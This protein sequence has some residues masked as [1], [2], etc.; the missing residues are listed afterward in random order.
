MKKHFYKFLII[1]SIISFG[2]NIYQFTKQT[3]SKEK[4]YLLISPYKNNNTID[5]NQETNT[6]IH[7]VNLKPKLEKILKENDINQKNIGLFL[8]N[9]KTGAWLGINEKS[10]FVPASL[11]KI[12]IMMAILKKA[13]R[14]EINLSN[15]ITIQKEDMDKNAGDLWKKG[16]NYQISYW[17]LIKKMIL[18]S[19]NTAKNALKRQLTFE[20]LN[21]IFSHVGIP[22]PYA[23]TN[24]HTITPRDYNR[25]FKSLYFS[26]FL[27]PEFSE[28]AIDISTDTAVENLISHQIPKGIKI[29]HKFGERPNGLHDCGII[30]F[31]ENPY[32][33]CIMTEDIELSKAK[34]II[35]KLSKEIY[36]YISN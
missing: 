7:Y 18:I 12:P 30:Y 11:L 2:I 8:Q 23:P 17:D 31:P 32:F 29:A 22:N 9:S 16:P 27:N 14:E 25:I 13:E 21:A 36:D 5:N 26:T 35:S 20:E 15:K 3:K 6:P 1:F 33:L 10:N 24:G 4:N 34:T 28:K 19:D